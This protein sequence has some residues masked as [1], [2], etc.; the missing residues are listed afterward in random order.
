MSEQLKAYLQY[1]CIHSWHPKYYKYIDEWINN[2]L[3]YQLLY[4]ER[5]MKNLNFSI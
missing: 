1:R 4:F 5:E 2:V 3:P